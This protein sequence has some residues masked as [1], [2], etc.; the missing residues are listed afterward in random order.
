MCHKLL[1]TAALLLVFTVWTCNAVNYYK[2]SKDA[3]TFS[4]P[5]RNARPPTRNQ[6]LSNA[7]WIRTRDAPVGSVRYRSPMDRRMVPASMLFDDKQD[8]RDFATDLFQ[9]NER[10]N[11]FRRIAALLQEQEDF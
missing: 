1:A 3:D 2:Q 9:S 7:L 8:K 5:S 11:R 10:M 6:D 4:P